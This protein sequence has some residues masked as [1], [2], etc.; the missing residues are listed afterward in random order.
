MSEKLNLLVESSPQIHH[1]ES[2][3][4]IMWSVVICLLPAGIWGVWIFGTKALF[5]LITSVVASVLSEALMNF[6]LK[7][8]RF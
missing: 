8:I 5:V 4:S 6:I 7:K 2:T 3:A 1:S